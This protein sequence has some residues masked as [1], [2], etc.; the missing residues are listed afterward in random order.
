MVCRILFDIAR[1]FPELTPETVWNTKTR[2]QM[3]LMYREAQRLDGQNAARDAMLTYSAVSAAIMHKIAGK[4]FPEFQQMLD[5]LLG[6]DAYSKAPTPIHKDAALESLQVL[7]S[8]SDELGELQE[9]K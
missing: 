7:P 1:A 8:V 5:G 6:E 4:E 2:G 3:M 9:L